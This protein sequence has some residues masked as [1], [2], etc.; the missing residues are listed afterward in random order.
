MGQDCWVALKRQI[1]RVRR[2][3]A[4]SQPRKTRK[5]KSI[6]DTSREYYY[7]FCSTHIHTKKKIRI[8]F[9]PMCIYFRIRDVYCCN[10]HPCST[11][12]FHCLQTLSVQVEYFPMAALVKT[13][14][15]ECYIKHSSRKLTDFI[16]SCSKILHH[17]QVEA[18][19]YLIPENKQTL[20][21]ILGISWVRH[22][23]QWLLLRNL[24]I[25]KPNKAWQLPLTL[26]PLKGIWSAVPSPNRHSLLLQAGWWLTTLPAPKLEW[27]YMANEQ[28][29]VLTIH[30]GFYNTAQASNSTDARSQ[31]LMALYEN[32]PDGQMVQ[33]S[34]NRY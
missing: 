14:L 7:T 16:C 5:N 32:L 23:T 11:N 13:N 18:T 12:V 1:I 33:K 2:C 29:S 20:S 9:L 27:L 6:L 31:E 4:L 17:M 3:Q 28:P 26:L 8:H 21:S 19:L 25:T 30:C 10:A 34:H 22:A 24:C 15:S